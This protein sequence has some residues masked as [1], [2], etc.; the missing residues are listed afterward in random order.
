MTKTDIVLELT[1][2]EALMLH[3][4]ATSMSNDSSGR[5]HDAIE[6]IGL[7][8]AEADP[9]LI[10][11]DWT[12]WQEMGEPIFKIMDEG[13]STRFLSPT[14]KRSAGPSLQAVRA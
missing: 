2:E 10:S 13:G 7:A 8:L 3:V 5:M 12:T 9:T 14:T 6:A 11:A 1:R 4:L